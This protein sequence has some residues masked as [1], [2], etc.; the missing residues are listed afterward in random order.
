[1]IDSKAA[2]YCS[3]SLSDR[4]LWTSNSCMDNE[5]GIKAEFHKTCITS[6]QL[7]KCLQTAARK[8]QFW[9][10]SK[11]VSLPHLLLSNLEMSPKGHTSCLE[12][13]LDYV[14]AEFL[15]LIPSLTPETTVRHRKWVKLQSSNF[16]MGVFVHIELDPIH[17]IFG[18]VF[19]IAVIDRT[20][21]LSVQD[22]IGTSF[23]THYNSF[24]IKAK[25]DV[26]AVGIHRL[27]DHRP[28][29]ARQNFDRNDKDLYISL[30]YVITTLGS[31]VSSLVCTVF[32]QYTE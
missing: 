16:V 19:D 32:V 24:V 7:Q 6:K 15:C 25:V 5:T 18:K 26:R 21:I 28:L 1:M 14:Q 11:L 12:N 29:H 10:C 22:C 8:H 2:L 23:S 31:Q 30:P 4:K 17:P 13:E 9:F 3:L 27:L 20:M